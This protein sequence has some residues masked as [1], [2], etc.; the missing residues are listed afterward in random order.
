M[1]FEPPSLC[2]FQESP[3]KL[4]QTEILSVFHVEAASVCAGLSYSKADKDKD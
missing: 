2:I 4:F 1:Q 3:V